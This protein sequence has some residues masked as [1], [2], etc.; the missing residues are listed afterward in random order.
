[1]VF[2]RGFGSATTTFK[3]T[4]HANGR[5]RTGFSP[6]LW[7]SL[8]D[9]RTLEF[10]APLYD[11]GTVA[12]QDAVLAKSDALTVGDQREMNSHTEIGARMLMRGSGPVMEMAV[13]IVASH[14]EHWDGSG[15]P[16]ALATTQIPVGARIVTLVL[17]CDQLRLG[18]TRVSPASHLAAIALLKMG[19]ADLCVDNLIHT[20]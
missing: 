15:Y 12:I 18:G 5:I 19:D 10:A 6:P 20:S 4:T 3:R 9:C 16:N 1:M 7:Q 14:H 17:F 13:R 2:E 11:I 8:K